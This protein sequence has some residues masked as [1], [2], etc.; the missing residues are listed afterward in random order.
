MAGYIPEAWYEEQQKEIAA[1]QRQAQASGVQ[2]DA[3]AMDLAVQEK[4]LVKEQL[5]LAEELETIE[6]LL[7]GEV[8][9]KVDGVQQWCEPKDKSLIVLTEHGVHLIMN[10]ILFYLN[11][12]TLL[13]NY[14]EET[15]KHKMEDFS[16]ALADVVFMEYE[17]VFCYPSF[18][19]CKQLL[20][21]RIDKQKDLRK[22]AYEL[23]GREVNEKEIKEELMQKIEGQIEKEITKIKEQIIKNKLKRFELIIREVQDA[24]HSTY[25]RAW[26]G[27]ERRTLRQHITISENVGVQN[28][29]PTR[30][31]NRG[32]LSIFGR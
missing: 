10:T 31:Q 20:L 24:V 2:Q 5:S 6:H 7:R 4:N 28:Q 16:T 22:F 30:R 9:E 17:K 21:D 15:I 8:L 23:A 18:Q 13:S 11:K 29:P 3:M 14:D 19:E 25:L 27:Q 1:A 32:I 12:N 26:N